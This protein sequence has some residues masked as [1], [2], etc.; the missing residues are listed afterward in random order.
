MR[1]YGWLVSGRLRGP[2]KWFREE[3]RLGTLAPPVVA[4]D[5]GGEPA[6]RARCPENS[7]PGPTAFVSEALA[8]FRAADLGAVLPGLDRPGIAVVKEQAPKLPKCFPGG[9]F[10][11]A[12]APELRCK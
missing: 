7:G 6:G 5:P 11:E 3:M 12:L 9:F 2:E 8:A 4:G 10:W 1:G